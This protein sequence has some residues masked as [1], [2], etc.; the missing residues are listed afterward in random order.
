MDVL[1]GAE[2]LIRNHRPVIA[3]ECATRSR[4]E[5]VQAWLNPFG[6]TVV[7]VHN[8]TPT[9]IF[10]NTYLKRYHLKLFD[11]LHHFTLHRA[12]AKNGF[13]DDNL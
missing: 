9:F 2:S 11:Y 7:D 5:K 3:V 1:K 13:A 4:L 10:V 12:N 8:Y 6:Y